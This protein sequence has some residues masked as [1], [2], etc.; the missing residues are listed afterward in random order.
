M[1]R[2]AD[3]L[4]QHLGRELWQT[5]TSAMRHGG[6][7][8]ERLKDTPPG[9]ALKAAANHAERVLQELPDVAKRDGLVISGAGIAFGNLLSELR[10]TVIDKLIASERSYRG[11]LAGFRHG[12]DVVYTLQ[13]VARRAERNELVAF[14]E[15]WREARLPLVAAIEKELSWFAEHP[16][17]ALKP[18]RPLV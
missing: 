14:C 2:D 10:D 15:R 5:E 18:A 4:L 13:L 3:A 16:D 17:E 8:A 1:T 11:T 6:R 9:H 12:I 7:E